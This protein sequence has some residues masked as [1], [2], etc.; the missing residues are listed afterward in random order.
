MVNIASCQYR[1]EALPSFAAWAE[2]QARLVAACHGD[3]LLYP[4]YASLELLGWL[5]SRTAK[6]LGRSLDALQGGREVFVE[7][8]R[9]LS[10]GFHKAI[11]LPSIPWRL[12]DGRVVNRAWYADNGH[13]R[14]FS[15]KQLLTRFETERWSISPGEPS[16]LLDFRAI[17][18]SVQ[19][20]YDIE[21]PQLCRR[22]VEAGARFVL[23][24]SCT[25]TLAGFHRVRIG[26][27]AR[28]LEN[29]TLVVQSPLVGEAPFAPAIFKNQGKAGFFTAPDYGLPDNGVLAESEQL[30]PPQSLW[31]SQQIDLD[32]LEAVRRDGQV[33]NHRDWPKQWP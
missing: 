29:Q 18:F 31:L 30:A 21:F 25:D 5:P 20:C 19:I 7:T 6:H 11:V 1:V 14:G 17:P 28:A 13:I 23:V 16:P 27:Q 9:A 10:A 15:D 8:F 4:E 22:H 12:D 24:P 3:L 32:A 33:L 26:C 2:K